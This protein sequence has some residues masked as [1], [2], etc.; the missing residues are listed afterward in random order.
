MD[1]EVAMDAGSGSGALATRLAGHFTTPSRA[2][3]RHESGQLLA[4]PWMRWN[5]PTA[6]C[7]Y[8]PFEA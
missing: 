6:M 3:I 1:R 4:R 7:S 5:P 8:A 2:A